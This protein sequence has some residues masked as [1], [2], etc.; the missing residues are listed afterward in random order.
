MNSIESFRSILWKRFVTD[1]F[2]KVFCKKDILKYLQNS[3]ENN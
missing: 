2:P 1:G 3:Q